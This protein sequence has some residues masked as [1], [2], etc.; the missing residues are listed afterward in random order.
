MIIIF[1]EK[2]KEGK[3]TF[4]QREL[5]DLLKKAR[6]EGYAEGQASKNYWYWTPNWSI[7]GTMSTTTLPVTGTKTIYK[8]LFKVADPKDWQYNPHNNKVIKIK[9]TAYCNSEW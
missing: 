6:D 5:E 8:Y 1:K 4:T 9:L 3:F 7:T 2:N